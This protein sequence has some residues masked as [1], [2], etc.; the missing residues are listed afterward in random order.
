MAMGVTVWDPQN[1]RIV[2]AGRPGRP[3]RSD[4]N[5]GIESTEL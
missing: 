2:S 5:R 1:G 3:E 4:Q